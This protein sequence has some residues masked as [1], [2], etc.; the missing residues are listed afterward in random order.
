MATGIAG[1]KIEGLLSE[2][3]CT[4]K[5]VVNAEA[6]VFFCLMSFQLLPW[7]LQNNENAEELPESHAIM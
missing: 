2:C 3:T 7:T 6:P 1:S 4:A 5:P